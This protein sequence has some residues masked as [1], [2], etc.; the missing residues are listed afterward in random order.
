M[1]AE[2]R[3]IVIIGRTSSGKSSVIGR[4]SELG[5]NTLDEMGR[6]ILKFRKSFDSSQSEIEKR[7]ILMYKFQLSFEKAAEG[8]TF[9]ERGLPCSLVFAKYLLCY[10]PKEMDESIMRDRYHKI[11]VLEGLD[12]KADGVRI[13]TDEME[14]QKIQDLTEK[15]YMDL[16]YNLL[17]VPKFSD[18]KEESLENRVKMILDHLD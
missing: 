8:T 18:N 2:D 15:T 5:Y 17:Y 6:T 9:F 3:K 10:V 12:F 13:E 7:Q 1:T 16:G 14:A 11:F 4:L